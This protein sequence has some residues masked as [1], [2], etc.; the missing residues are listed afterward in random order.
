MTTHAAAEQR[1]PDVIGLVLYAFPL[2]S[3]APKRDRAAHLP[4]VAQPM[5]F[6]TGTRDKMAD[7]ALLA[8]VVGELPAAR[9]HRLDTADHGFKTLERR[10]DPVG[11]YVEA[12]QV[13]AAWCRGL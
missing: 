12:A 9:L 8:D 13:A 5:L 2:H 10:K 1:L 6:L 7:N 4:A 3:G 11:V